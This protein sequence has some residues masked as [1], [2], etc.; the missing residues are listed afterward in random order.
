MDVDFGSFWKYSHGHKLKS[1]QELFLFF[2]TYFFD[3]SEN[4]IWPSENFF[5]QSL[6]LAMV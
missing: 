3:W 5:G 2:S 4:E 1:A 6:C